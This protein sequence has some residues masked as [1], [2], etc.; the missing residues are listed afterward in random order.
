VL[1]LNFFLWE[2]SS[3]SN[4]GV[5]LQ[6]YERSLNLFFFTFFL[7]CCAGRGYIVAFTQVLT[8]H[9]IYQFEFTTSTALL[10]LPLPDSWSIFSRYHFCIYIHVHTFFCTIFTLL[11]HSPTTSSLTLVPALPTGQD[12][13]HPLILQFCRK[14]R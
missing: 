8:M 3:H 11:P 1:I 7:Y 13:V 6:V 10:Y 4:Y 14:K 2:K 5:D 12:L 9:Q